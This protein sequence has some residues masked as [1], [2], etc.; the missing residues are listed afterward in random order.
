MGEPMRSML[1]AGVMKALRPEQIKPCHD[2]EG[3]VDPEFEDAEG[4][5][6]NCLE[7]W[8]ARCT[9]ET[10]GGTDKMV[11]CLKTAWCTHE[12]VCDCWK[13]RAM[14]SGSLLQQPSPATPSSSLG[15]A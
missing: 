6:C 2:K 4:W 15:L 13:K 9:E 7:N 8:K 3:C 14:C 11:A 5:G 10:G 12:K 1:A